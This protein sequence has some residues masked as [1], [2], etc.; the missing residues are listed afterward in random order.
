[1]NTVNWGLQYALVEDNEFPNRS[2][3]VTTRSRSTTNGEEASI[4]DLIVLNSDL[5]KEVELQH[6]TIK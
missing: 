1:M 4:R 6:M 2:F 5:V 3:R